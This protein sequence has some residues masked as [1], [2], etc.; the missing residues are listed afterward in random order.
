MA[1]GAGA[2][3]GGVFGTPTAQNNAS[4]AA[5]GIYTVTKTTTAGN[6]V[7]LAASSNAFCSGNVG[8][9][10]VQLPTHSPGTDTITPVWFPNATVAGIQVTSGGSGYGITVPTCTINNGGTA[11]CT[12]NLSGGAVAGVTITNEGAC[13]SAC[14]ISF[15][16]PGTGAA[17]SI[18][19]Y[20]QP[21]SG[22][23]DY[24]SYMW[25]MQNVAGTASDV[26]TPPL[27]IYSNQYSALSVA[28]VSGASTSAPFDVSAG[29]AAAGTPITTGSFT[30]TNAN[31][32]VFCISRVEN[33]TNSWTA[34][35]NYTVLSAAEPASPNNYQSMQYRILTTGAGLSQTASFDAGNSGVMNMI[36]S[37]FT[38]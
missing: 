29:A 37:A 17:A 16:G 6:L 12:A 7:V 32:I 26:F 35:T 1:W 33:L 22:G 13:T 14:T 28:E 25:Y 9:S 5:T 15:G 3:G 34:G 31:E 27:I 38:H 20:G 30:T 24:C 23:S 21:A 36:C 8:S 11:T 2:S 10:G 19:A 18:V 4:G